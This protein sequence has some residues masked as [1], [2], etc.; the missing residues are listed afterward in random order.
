MKDETMTLCPDEEMALLLEAMQSDA[1]DEIARA[2]QLIDTYPEDPRL[3]FLRGS[4]LAGMGRAIEAHA[5]LSRAVELAPEFILARFQL[6]FFELTSGEAGRALATWGPLDAIPQDHYL[7]HFVR[8]LRHLIRDEFASA[9][10]ALRDG[11]AVNTENPPLNRD[12][13]LIIDECTP[14][15]EGAAPAHLDE[16]SATS[17]LLG[18]FGSGTKH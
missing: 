2:E 17:V 12:M 1:P 10:A 15:A 13:Q 3:H 14:L 8:G 4:A 9:I 11:Q 7:A 5:A 18:Q 6:G 16:A